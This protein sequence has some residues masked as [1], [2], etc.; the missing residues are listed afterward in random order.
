MNSRKFSLRSLISRICKKRSASAVVLI[1][2]KPEPTAARERVRS[3]IEPLEGRIAPAIL[4]NA[5]TLTYSDLDGDAVTVTFSKDI[6]NLTSATLPTA[7]EA[8]FK[9]SAGKAHIGAA[10]GT[11]DVPQ[12]LQLIDLGAVPTRLVNGVQQSLVAGV[13]FTVNSVVN[14]GSGLPP[15]DGF[16]AIGAIKA[17]NNA[18]GTVIIDGD[19]GQIDA[20]TG[21]SK[22]GL[23]ILVTESIGKFGTSTQAGSPADGLTSDIKGRL[24]RLVVKEDVKGYIHVV[25]STRLIGGVN[26]IIQRGTIGQI[27]IGGSLIG[28][29]TVATAS[30]NTGRIEA[31]DLGTVSIGTDAADG[32]FGG[33]GKRSGSIQAL[34]LL[35]SVTVSGNVEGGTAEDAGSINSTGTIGIVKIGG[36]LKGGTGARSASVIGGTAV[37][38]VTIGSAAAHHDIIGSTGES[39]GYVF[40]GTNLGAVHVFGNLT[41]GGSFHSGGIFVNGSIASVIV[42]GNVSGGT[43]KS[44][45]A[46]EALR[47]IGPVLIGGDL[48]GGDGAG[49][50]VVAAGSALA[51]ISVNGD[52]TGGK[53]VNSGAI[54]GG[55]NP[56][57]F[58]RS[59]GNVTVVGALGGGEGNGSGAIFSGGTIAAVKIGTGLATGVAVQGGIGALSGTIFANGGITSVTTLRGVTGGS[60]AGSASI[61]A[62]GN[63]GS[64]SITGDLTGGTGVGSASIFSHENATAA[65]PIAGNIGTVSIT[66][67]LKSV[68]ARSGLIEAD[69]VLG[70]AILGSIEDG[71]IVSGAG[72]VRPGPTASISVTG[73]ID[74]GTIQIGG[75]LGSLTSGGMMDADIR[76]AHDLGALRVN[77]DVLDSLI[78]ARGQ[79]VRGLTTDVAIG[80]ITITGSVTNSSIRAGYDIAGGAVNADAQI[81]A[82]RVVGN[83]TASVLAAG[84]TDGADDLF[85]TADDRLIPVANNA[86]IIA[87]IASVIIDG[88]MVGTATGGDHFGFISQRIGSFKANGVAVPLTAT[89][90]QAFEVGTGGDTTVREVTLA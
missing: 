29:P 45:G 24:A 44:S 46:I 71:A 48:S 13:S 75:R 58:V 39:S 89:A 43:E 40:A 63:L 86:R 15:G 10:N 68:G 60:G 30:D 33:G 83:W 77:G 82:V 42:D 87:Q 69:G 26:T 84:V 54:S 56:A 37:G 74:G 51:R 18:L 4:V 11:D 72:F 20:G 59:L 25:D 41:G 90:G 31:Y 67:K 1:S 22:V 2:K 47:A 57:S 27:S 50:G 64:V 79:A 6:F 9:F 35:G 70:R 3:G 49:S 61:H 53:G 23:G 34:H 66:G 81:G 76:V 8:V 38:P 55:H 12:Q 32:I 5:H 7:L 19:L 36:D 80:S 73:L 21:T 62:D 65:R 85:G 16:A 52:V 78:T 17:G 28:N 14:P 88:S